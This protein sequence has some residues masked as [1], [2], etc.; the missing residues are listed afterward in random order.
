VIIPIVIM[1]T[2]LQMVIIPSSY[3]NISL[4]RQGVILFCV[5][6]V[7]L[8]IHIHYSSHSRL[9]LLGV[10]YHFCC[11]AWMMLIGVYPDF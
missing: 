3:S 10:L 2:G 4:V 11:T 1:P 5:Y 6:A 9:H 7:L 8:I